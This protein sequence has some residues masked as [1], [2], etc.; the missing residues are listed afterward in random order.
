MRKVTTINLNNNAYQIDEDGYEA[1]RA[2][3]DR[4]ARALSGNPDREEILSDLE[5]AIADKCRV[6][7]GPHK[8][9]VSGAEID[10]ILQEM[11]P[12]AGGA[13]DPADAGAA[14]GGA[15][16]HAVPRTGSGARRL[17]R[18]REGMVWGGICSGLAA[19]VGMDVTLVRV[20]LVLLTIFTAFIP[21]IF[22]YIVMCFVVPMAE[23]PE[24]ISAAHGQ[25]FRAQEVVDRVKKKRDDWRAERRERRY[26]KRSMRQATWW[27][28]RPVPQPPPGAAARLTGGV[29]LPLLTVLSAAW[30]SV[31]ATVAYVLWHVW[32]PTRF[33]WP[34]GSWHG[35]ADIPRWVAM[36]VVIALYALLALPIGA[37]RRTS[38]YYANGGRPHGWADAWSGLLW[39]ALVAVLLLGAWFIMPQLQGQLWQ[40]LHQPVRGISI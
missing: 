18:L 4:A 8:T 20:V 9:V 13:E 3:L 32:Y 17:F 16:P 15:A 2:Y 36:G 25:P 10:R 5:Q 33:N 37:A 26:G 39:V 40:L 21:C 35:P 19:F 27:S 11:G 28:P 7:L 34:P 23:T 6:A 24:E 22:I 31:M 29:L 30:F 12:V 38:L 14:E 1:L